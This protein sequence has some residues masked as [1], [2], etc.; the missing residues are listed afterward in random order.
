MADEDPQGSHSDAQMRAAVIAV[1][2][3]GVCLTL[4]AL[5]F[6]SGRAALGVAIGGGIATVNLL[7]FARIGNAFLGRKGKTAPWAV[8]ALLKLV[9][10]F[11]G[12]WLILASGVISGL[13]LAVGYGALPL[14]IT[15]ASLF[16]PKPPDD[17]EEPPKR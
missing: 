16:G 2:L 1:A 15:L 13:S 17:I 8:I 3:C 7:V 11:G 10:L 9:V 4:G 5:V 6:F 12:I 14:G